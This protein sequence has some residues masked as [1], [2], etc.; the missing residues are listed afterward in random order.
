MFNGACR[1]L[2]PNTDVA[3]SYRYWVPGT[4]PAEG[5]P[6]GCV[7]ACPATQY[8]DGTNHC[9]CYADCGGCNAGYYCDTSACACVPIPG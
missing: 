8:C 9:V 3:V 4:C 2:Q 5:C 1:P 6:S 7:P